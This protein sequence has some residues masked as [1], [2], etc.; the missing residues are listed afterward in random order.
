MSD[1]AKTSQPIP[2]YMQALFGVLGIVFLAE[3]V[4]L[5]FVFGGAKKPDGANPKPSEQTIVHSTVE[6]PPDLPVHVSSVANRQRPF[7]HGY[8]RTIRNRLSIQQIRSLIQ[9]DGPSVVVNCSGLARTLDGVP[10][11]PGKIYGTVATGTYPATPDPTVF[12]EL[13]FARLATIKEGKAELPTISSFFRPTKNKKQQG[14]AQLAIRI[15]LFQGRPGKDLELGTYDTFCVLRKTG[16]GAFLLPSIVEGPFVNLVTSD[17]PTRCVI[18]LST[19]VPTTPSLEL[20]GKQTFP[21]SGK[22]TTHAIELSGLEPDRAYRYRVTVGDFTTRSFPLRTAPKRGACGFR[23]AFGGCS[24]ATRDDGGLQAHM[25]CN[26]QVLSQM[27]AFADRKDARFLLQ[28]GDL[29]E[30]Y[31]TDVDDI[32]TQFYGWRHALRGFLH[33]RPV[34]PVMGNHEALI[35]HFSDGSTFGLSLDRWPYDEA[36]AEAIFAEQFILPTNGPTPSDPRRPPY[37]EN[38]YSFQ[39]GCVKCIAV[40]T[41]YWYSSAPDEHGGCPGGYILPDQMKWI[42]KELDSAAKDS[43]V[44]YV[45]LYTQEAVF[46]N[47][48]HVRD[49][50]WYDGNN[51]ILASSWNGKKLTKEKLGILEVRDRFLR[52]VHAHPKVVAVLSSDEHSYSKVLI[53]KDVDVGDIKKDDTSNDGQITLKPSSRNQEGKS[54]TASPLSDLNHPVWYFVSGGFGAPAYAYRST[55]WSRYWLQRNEKETKFMYSPQS[56]ILMFHVTDNKMGM[57][58]YNLS[59]GVIDEVDDLMAVRG[60]NDKEMIWDW[61]S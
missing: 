16:R 39:Y 15:T 46:P 51:N 55:P 37:R 42:E 32:R 20:D 8:P 29:V 34:Y 28:G 41:N 43:T 13:H 19:N 26:Y 22:G 40:N 57:T 18:S 35:H 44:K 54:E 1:Q 10:L 52:L 21:S 14:I 60:G 17:D 61:W 12:R 6:V 50:M 11:R 49:G 38:V 24:R 58:V 45:V 53:T 27:A 31:T 9:Q 47:G 4:L 25:G 23:F 30:G 2:I 5:Y 33:S 3:L 7:G 56:H 48:K 36:S 59:G